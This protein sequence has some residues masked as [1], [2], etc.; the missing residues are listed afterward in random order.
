M[1]T[2]GSVLTQRQVDADDTEEGEE[3]L[4]EQTEQA[5]AIEAEAEA[6]AEKTK[7]LFRAL[8]YAPRQGALEHDSPYLR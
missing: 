3:A 6:E 8:S 4:N 2:S 7:T 5:E 1:F